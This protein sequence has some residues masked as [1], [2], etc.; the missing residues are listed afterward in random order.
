MDPYSVEVLVPSPDPG[1]KS[2][3]KYTNTVHIKDDLNFFVS[4][5][6]F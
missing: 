5:W 1:V 2:T 6:A 3:L 4:K